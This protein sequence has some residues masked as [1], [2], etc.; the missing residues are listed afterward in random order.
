MPGH[1]IGLR[2]RTSSLWLAELQAIVYPARQDEGLAWRRLRRASLSD[3]PRWGDDV[4]SF[5]THR[6]EGG[7]DS[8][9]VQ[10]LQGHRDVSTTQ[11][12]AHL[13]NRGPNAVQ[14]PEDRLLGP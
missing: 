12:Y 8:R 7:R 11:S 9:T 1:R 2:W 4:A 3:T 14:S 6:L 13:L 5:A 10:E